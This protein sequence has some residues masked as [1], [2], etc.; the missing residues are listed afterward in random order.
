MENSRPK[1]CASDQFFKTF[2]E[3]II[4]I[5]NSSRGYKKW[6]YFITCFVANKVIIRKGNDKPSSS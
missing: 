2:K 1:Y 3:E 5:L 6:A 4:A